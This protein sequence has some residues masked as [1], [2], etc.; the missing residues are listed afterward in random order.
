MNN[1]TLAFVLEKETDRKR[2]TK[3]GREREKGKRNKEKTMERQ[4]KL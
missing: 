2:D 3:K 1:S 4:E